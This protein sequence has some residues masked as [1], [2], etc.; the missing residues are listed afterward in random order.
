ML[1]MTHLPDA[2]EMQDADDHHDA[3]GEAARYV[4]AMEAEA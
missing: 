4:R 2:E 1:T 3:R